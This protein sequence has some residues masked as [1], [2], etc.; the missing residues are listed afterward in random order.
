MKMNFFTH[1]MWEI[2]WIS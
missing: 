1:M 2:N